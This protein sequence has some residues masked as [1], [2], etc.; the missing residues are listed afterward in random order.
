MLK[1]QVTVITC[2]TSYKLP[3]LIHMTT[4]IYTPEEEISLKNEL[5]DLVENHPR[6]YFNSLKTSNYAKLLAFI[7]QQT[8]KLADSFYKISTKVNW[9]LNNITDFP[10][11]PTCGKQYG[12]MQNISATPR[13]NGSSGYFG[14]CSKSCLNNS[15]SHINNIKQT[16]LEK[17]GVDNPAKAFVVKEKIKQ[18]CLEKYGVEYVTQT[19]RFKNKAVNTFIVKYGVTNPNKLKTIRKKI[20]DT[21][22]EKF[23]VDSYFQTE[24][25]HKRKKSKI[26]Y[27]NQQFDSKAELIVYKR[28]KEL[29][30]VVQR[31]PIS[32]KYN[33]NNKIHYYYPDF[34]INGHLVE[35]KGDHF[36]RINATTGKEELWCPF[37]YYSKNI[38]LTPNQIE[39]N[40]LRNSAKYRCMVENNVKIIKSSQLSDLDTVLQS[41]I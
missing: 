40:R 10:I 1:W 9:V 16:C 25:F 28:C 3:L 30:Y 11:C 12:Q 36:L 21:C 22:K 17:Y 34:R 41:L 19:D 13:K 37:R 2:R 32:I 23:G 39:F 20:K 29:G 5:K 15:A 27:D 24:E 7:N 35:V 31:T 26:I 38:K 33:V 18:T 14:F 6:S 4:I 8:P